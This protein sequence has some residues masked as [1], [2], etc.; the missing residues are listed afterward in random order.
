MPRVC[1]SELNRESELPR[2]RVA[3]TVLGMMLRSSRGRIRRRPDEAADIRG[4]HRDGG[5]SDAGDPQRVAESVG[6][7]LRKALDHF[8]RE[9][10]NTVE[11][12]PCRN[13]PPFVLPRTFDLG[14][15]TPE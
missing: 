2:P 7:D 14:F 10:W 1:R 6:P 5:R 12:E 15:L 13:S 11:R 4:K 8:L 3:P 9:P